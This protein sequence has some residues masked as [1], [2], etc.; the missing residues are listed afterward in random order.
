MSFGVY[1]N[2]V[3]LDRAALVNPIRRV[4]GVPMPLLSCSAM[5]GALSSFIL[6]AI[7]ASSFA[8]MPQRGAIH[9]PTDAEETT[10]QLIIKLRDP[11]L[12]NIQARVRA[13]GAASATD[14][15]HKRQ[16]SGNAHVVKLAKRLNKSDLRS[17]ARRLAADP[18]VASVEPDFKM[19]AQQLP[20]DPMYAQQW[21]YFEPA[22]GINLPAAWDITTGSANVVV[23]VIDTGI[24]PHADLAGKILPGY[25]FITDVTVANDGDGRDGDASDPGDYGC[26]GGGAA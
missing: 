10:D 24:R 3:C 18:N 15:T 8:G 16:M 20:N 23:A 17:L 21:H 6:S 1:R 14:L 13:V 7:A 19:Y 26:N 5:R 2:S 12:N 9:A 11:S 25:D 22:G 4:L